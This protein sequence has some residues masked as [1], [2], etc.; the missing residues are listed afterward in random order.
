MKKIL[1]V[2]TLAMFAK[3]EFAMAIQLH[4]ATNAQLVEELQ[5]R[6]NNA[7]TTPSKA[8]SVSVSPTY[9]GSYISFSVV[10][11]NSGQNKNLDVYIGSSEFEGKHYGRRLAEE[12]NAKF[13]GKMAN[14]PVI[15]SYCSSGYFKRMII[16]I[17]N[18]IKDLDEKYIG[19][20]EQ[21]MRDSLLWNASINVN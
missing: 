17:T 19:N 12:L 3:T 16:N 11:V 8:L 1:L 20:S 9:G 14:N 7:G 6:L 13:L 4:E 18:L 15:V 21:C 2:M 5:R 10:D